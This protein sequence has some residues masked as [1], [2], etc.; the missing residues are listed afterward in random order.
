[1]S[2]VSIEDS[3]CD[4]KIQKRVLRNTGFQFFLGIES[5]WLKYGLI[6][7]LHFTLQFES[8]IKG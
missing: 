4:K 7:S 2:F 8:P 1:M 3:L 6:S 5:A